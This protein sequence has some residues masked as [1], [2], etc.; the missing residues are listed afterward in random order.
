V[1]AAVT[2]TVRAAAAVLLCLVSS[3]LHAAQTEERVLEQRVKAA[4]IYRFI[5]FVTWPELPAEGPLVIG[6]I[7]SDVITEELRRISAS[8]ATGGRAL[9]VRRIGAE[10]P[11]ASVHLLF[12][13]ESERARLPQLARAA[14]R[15]LIVTEAEGALATGSV[16]NFV[17]VDGRVRFEISPEAAEKRNLRLSSRLLALAQN[18]RGSTP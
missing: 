9:E 17:L 7:G 12:V 15:A 2:R 18:V 5:E 10:A 11:P 8:R 13:A 6:V 4:Y 14:P 1:A 16:I 3:I